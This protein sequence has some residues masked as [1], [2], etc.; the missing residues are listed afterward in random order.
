MSLAGAITDFV[1]PV[2]FRVNNQAITTTAATVYEEGSATSLANGRL[3]EIEGRLADGVVTASRVHFSDP[4]RPGED[5]EV[6]GRI[7][8]FVSVASFKVEGQLVDATAASFSNGGAGD[9]AN[10]L[11]V[12]VKGPVA[13][14]VLRARTVEIDR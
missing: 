12:H 5:A 8:D 7:T 1:S 6:E 11:Q 10:G 14:G 13:Q 9:L 3:V 2:N 4:R